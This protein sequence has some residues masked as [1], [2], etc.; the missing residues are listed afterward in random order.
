MTAW[1]DRCPTDAQV[2]LLAFNGRD[3][4]SGEMVG[5][6]LFALLSLMAYGYDPA[7]LAGHFNFD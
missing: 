2:T 1:L 7:E 3:E 5:A 6:L 4:L